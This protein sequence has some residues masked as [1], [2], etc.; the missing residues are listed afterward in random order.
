MEDFPLSFPNLIDAPGI[1][2]T[3][4]IG[5]AW[6]E[7]QASHSQKGSPSPTRPCTVRNR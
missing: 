7:S 6:F 4:S 3:V 2:A 5:L 1:P